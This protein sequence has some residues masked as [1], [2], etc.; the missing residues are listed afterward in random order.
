MK[1]SKLF[2]TVET[3][4]ITKVGAIS[5]KYYSVDEE[6]PYCW[7]ESTVLRNKAGIK[8]FQELEA[9]E[10]ACADASVIDVIKL[11]EKTKVIDIDVWRKVHKLLFE[12]VY[13]WAGELR[14]VQMSKGASLFAHPEYIEKAVRSLLSQLA[15]EQLDMRDKQHLVDRLCHYYAE[16][17]AIHPFREGNGRVQ[18][19][20]LNEIARRAG[21]RIL[22]QN[23]DIDQHLKAVLRSF[24]GD[25]SLL[26]RQ[27]N[28]IIVEL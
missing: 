16:M 7:P 4:L 9:F 5:P 2:K 17:N 20:I 14:T 25:L 3:P 28:D 22:W 19:L 13:P 24:Y 11:L 6:D 26:K 12:D 1:R 21:A 8:N 15:A 10:D 18:K 27:M 23:L